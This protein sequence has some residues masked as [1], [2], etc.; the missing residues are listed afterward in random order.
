MHRIGIDLGGTKIEAAVLG[1]DQSVMVR[2]RIATEQNGG[3]EHIL[4]RIRLIYDRM[5]ERIKGAPHKLGIGM[6]GAISP[7]TGNL[8]NSNTICLNHQPLKEDIERL[9]GRK[10]AM[11][12]DANCFAVAEALYGAGK[13]AQLVFG[14]IMGTGCGGGICYQGKVIE[15]LQMIA[16]EW[17]HMSIDPQGPK[18]YCGANGCVETFISGGGLEKRYLR[19]TGTSLNLKEIVALFRK[20]DLHATKFMDIF[21]DHFGRALGNLINILDPDTV[22]LGG[23]VSNIGE[24]YTEGVERVRHCVL[25][26]EFNT[27]I[28]PN[29]L[30]DSAGVIG[31][32]LIGV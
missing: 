19:E 9:F 17:G 21:F 12:N 7:R 24:L 2:E 29:H 1:L 8:K 10:V 20:K 14:V 11:Q 13:G 22:V 5:V 26:G 3:Y 27:P 31:A 4:D 32:A 18:C 28:V 15:G 16:G 6:P 30:G 23:G 25:G